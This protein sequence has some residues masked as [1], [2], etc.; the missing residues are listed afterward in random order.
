MLQLTHFNF[1]FSH[2]SEHRTEKVMASITAEMLEKVLSGLNEFSTDGEIAAINLS[3]QIN[4]SKIVSSIDTVIQADE[5]SADEKSEIY[6]SIEDL[7]AAPAVIEMAS[8]E[9]ETPAT[10]ESSEDE[11]PL[12]VEASTFEFSTKKSKRKAIAAAA[13]DSV[14]KIL[15]DD[16]T[17]HDVVISLDTEPSADTTSLVASDETESETMPVI[18]AASSDL[19][20]PAVETSAADDVI[21]TD[22]RPSTLE[23]SSATETNYDDSDEPSTLVV[24]AEESNAAVSADAVACQDETPLSDVDLAQK[25]MILAGIRIKNQLKAM[26]GES[27]LNDATLTIQMTY[28]KA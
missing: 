25:N 15:A 17:N 21:L 26:Y 1:E 20:T 10:I 11:A 19:E 3:R 13:A 18:S 14:I 8:A 5:L 27:I 22:E 4:N 23:L 9:E 24:A 2:R 12:E 6:A 28:A 7:V 16:E